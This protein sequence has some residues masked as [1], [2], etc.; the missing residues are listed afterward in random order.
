VGEIYV[1][2]ANC[3]GAKTQISTG[4][5]RLGVWSRDSRE[6][7]FL[8]GNSVSV[9]NVNAAAGLVPGEPHRL[10]SWQGGVGFD[11]MPDSRRFV[12]F[13]EQP[14]PVPSQI[15]LVLGGLSGVGR[16]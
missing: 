14:A 2:P 16:R 10:F 4:G 15:N 7:F 13:E 3:G 11:V 6:F 1:S 9:V 8:S 12:M 5:G